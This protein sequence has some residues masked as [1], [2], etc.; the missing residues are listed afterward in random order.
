M[1]ARAKL[2]RV[3]ED[4]VAAD[5]LAEKFGIEASVS[6]ET[7][8]GR[9][10]RRLGEHLALVSISLAA[11]IIVSIPLGVIAARRPR[12][13]PLILTATGLIQTIPSL[14]LLVFMIPWLGI[15]AKPALA[16]LFLY[17]LLPDRSQHGHRLAR[18]SHLASGI[19]RGTWLTRACTA[20][21]HR[22]A[23]GGAIDLGGDQDRRSYQR[24]HS[25]ARRPDRRRRLWPTDT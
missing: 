23:D 16:A 1:N 6:T 24:R 5:F 10:S 2:D 20:L 19:G 3:P 22:T 17:S 12:L 11:A 15:G 13:G 25:H 7:W 9:L 14:A 18:H 21:A 4:R 8:V